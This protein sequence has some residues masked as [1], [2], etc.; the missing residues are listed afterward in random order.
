MLKERI[1][2][3]LVLI[4]FILQ[5]SSRSRV[6]TRGEQRELAESH[7]YPGITA[8]QEKTQ[9]ATGT[10]TCSFQLA[11]QVMAVLQ[12]ATVKVIL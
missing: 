9:A 6:C 3:V 5:E 10:N 7:T 12:R 11:G 2:N 1:I 8:T 4:V